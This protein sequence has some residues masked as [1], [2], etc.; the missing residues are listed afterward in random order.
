M[1][2]H[3]DIHAILRFAR[4]Y[5]AEK[6]PW[7]APALFRCK[8]HLTKQ[9]PLAAIDYSFNI[10]FNPDTITIIEKDRDRKQVLAELGFLW[11]HEISHVL[12]EHNVRATSIKAQPL[13]WNV[14]ADLEINDSNWKG[15]SMPKDFPGLLPSKYRLP[16]GQIAEYYYQKLFKN[17]LL[18]QILKDIGVIGIFSAEQRLDEGSGVHGSSRPWE[19]AADRI[20]K[21]DAVELE[22][23]RRGV[24]KEMKD[25]SSNI[26][27]LPG[28]WKRWIEEQLTPKVNW[29]KVL[30]HRMSVA[31]NNGIGNRIDYSFRRLSRR[32]SVYAPIIT[33]TLSGDL[34]ARVAVVVDTSGSMSKR[35]IGQAVAEVC[36]ILESF[37]VPVTV[38]PCDAKAYEPIKIAFPSDYF[39]LMNL[40]GGGGTDMIVGIE[41][42]VKLS[43][44]PDSILVLTDGYTPYPT[45]K[46]S[47][48]VVFGLLNFG[49]DRISTPPNPP[50]GKDTVVEIK[51]D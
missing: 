26:G 2:Q 22:M 16:N 19:I 40:A 14:A 43:P 15:L 46:Y 50:W 7:F 23:I 6:L 9:I 51:L 36:Q 17:D 21:L 31:I 5:C 27:T 45:Q 13:L 49:N 25:A 44:T 18:N 48:N 20:Q 37:Q 34:S 10:Y 11:I 8:I 35:Q 39:K 24:A 4:A 32:Q 28:N 30:R 47:I 1:Q 38:I 33:P 29:R 41:A 3:K 42:A 12:R